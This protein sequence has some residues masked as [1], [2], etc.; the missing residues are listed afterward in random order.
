[1]SF[2]TEEDQEF[3]D[4]NGLQYELL[5]EKTPEG[6]ERRGVL[7]PGFAFVG[8]LR[9]QGD[10]ALITCAS[11]DL[12]VLVPDGY[13]AM[14]FGRATSFSAARTTIWAATSSTDWLIST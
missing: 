9:T 10:G 1:M 8:D 12:L 4:C 6:T 5:T 2:L 11:C 7:L 3:L 14:R 13:A